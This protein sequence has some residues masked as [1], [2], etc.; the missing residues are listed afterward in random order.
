MGYVDQDILEAIKKGKDKQVLKCLYE[1]ELPKVKSY[2][3][4]CGGSAEEAY[5]IF[6]DTLLIFFKQVM[7]NK[8]DEKYE[9]GGFLYTISRNL[10]INYIKKKKRI[11]SV[12]DFTTSGLDSTVENILEDMVSTEKQEAVKT[13][14][15]KM[16]KRCIE[17]LTYSIFQELTME[18][19]CVR[20]KFTSVNAAKTANYRCKQ[21]LIKLIKEHLSLVE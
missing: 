2:I 12:E 18:D 19:I 13:V 20:M 8:F 5:D 14:F 1:E 9:V 4:R 10:W 11:V 6:Q 17:L 21:Q 3:L 16:N 7:T 15:A